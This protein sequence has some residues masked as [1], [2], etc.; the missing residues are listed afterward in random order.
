MATHK[1]GYNFVNECRKSSHVVVDRALIKRL[2][3]YNY[4][5]MGPKNG[6]SQLFYISKDKIQ[7]AFEPNDMRQML[8]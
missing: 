8:V 5:I 7:E 1:L 4:M 2:G 3:V 6:Y